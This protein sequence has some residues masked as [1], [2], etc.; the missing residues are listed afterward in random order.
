MR[1]L[2]KPVQLLADLKYDWRIRFAFPVFHQY[3]WSDHGRSVRGTV[4]Q[5]ND[6]ALDTFQQW[7]VKQLYHPYLD[8]NKL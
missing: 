8:M 3:H 6:S 2:S 4:E 1:V 7:G 5:E